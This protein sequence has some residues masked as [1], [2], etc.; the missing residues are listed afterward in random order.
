[1]SPDD[2][3]GLI[4][5]AT[6]DYVTGEVPAAL[7]KLGRATSEC[8]DSFEAWHALAEINLS[9]RRMDDALAAADKAHALRKSDPLI[10]ATLSRIWME[11]GDKAMAEKYGAMARVQ[12]WKE[13][14]SAPPQP[15]AGSLH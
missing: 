2:L 14:L 9:L 1:V 12:G 6:Y 3:Q 4:E 15:D 10:I 11:R 8:P 13:E 5:E 7:E